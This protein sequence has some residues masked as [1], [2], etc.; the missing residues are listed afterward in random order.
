MIKGVDSRC[1]PVMINEF[2]FS[3]G[4]LGNLY[5]F[6]GHHRSVFTK[7]RMFHSSM[8]PTIYSPHIACSQSLLSTIQ[9]AAYQTCRDQAPQR[10]RIDLVYRLAQ[11]Q[12]RF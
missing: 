4:F 8:I 5:H 3:G 6:Q 9:P 11:L 2:C 10:G 12:L 7:L 1:L